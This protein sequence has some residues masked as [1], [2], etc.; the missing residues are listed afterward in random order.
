MTNEQTQ[1]KHP[2]HQ[3][4]QWVAEGKEIEV[5]HTESGCYL[6]LDPNTILRIVLAGTDDKS[7]KQPQ[8]FRLKP[9]RHVHQDFIDA[10]ENGA[11]IQFLDYLQQQFE[12]TDCIEPLWT[13]DVK[14]RIKPEPKP[15]VVQYVF[16]MLDCDEMLE[17]SHSTLKATPKDNLKVVFDGESRKIK[18]VEI[19]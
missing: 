14:Y 1:T 10:F 13:S 9:E 15:D 2:Y 12:W 5:L 18:S 17:C 7:Y 19:I 8:D 3:V 6:Q 16:V 4:L 11:K